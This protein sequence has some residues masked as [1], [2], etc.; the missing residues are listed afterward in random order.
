MANRRMFEPL[1]VQRG[2]AVV[3]GNGTGAG[4]ADLTSVTGAGISA[5]THQATGTYRVELDDA[6]PLLLSAVAIV[7]HATADFV[8]MVDATDLT[9]ATPYVQFRVMQESAGALADT[10]L[11]SS[12]ILYV[13]LFFR[14]TGTV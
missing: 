11:T 12:E 5:I 1:C 14:N 10:D 13:T 9:A 6:Y 4:A 2:V 7:E 3:C 8:C